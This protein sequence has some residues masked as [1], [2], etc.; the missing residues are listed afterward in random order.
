MLRFSWIAPRAV[1]GATAWL[2]GA[3]LSLVWRLKPATAECFKRKRLMKLVLYTW[4]AA[5][6][7]GVGFYI[8]YYIL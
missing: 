4:L 3:Y 8:F 2:Y 1:V 7:L 5:A 6:I